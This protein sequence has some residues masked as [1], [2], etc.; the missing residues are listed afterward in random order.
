MPLVMRLLVELGIVTRIC[1]LTVVQR[2]CFGHR[3]W[4]WKPS[5]PWQGIDGQRSNPSSRNYFLVWARL[6]KVAER[7]T[8]VFIAMEKRDPCGHD[9][10]T[11]LVCRCFEGGRPRRVASHRGGQEHKSLV[12]DGCLAH[13]ARALSLALNPPLTNTWFVAL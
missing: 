8:L 6:G 11:R 2:A 10:Q 3:T 13:I 5:R 7:Q 9:R 12:G 1:H 4:R